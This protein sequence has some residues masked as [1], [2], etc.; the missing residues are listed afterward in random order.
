MLRR[1]ARTLLVLVAVLGLLPGVN[2]A[3]EHLGELIEHGHLAHSV[4][5]EHDPFGEEHGCT[6]VQ[7]QCPC[8]EGQ[9]VAYSI[10]GVGAADHAEWL[11]W[12][13]DADRARLRATS[14]RGPIGNDLAPANRSTA[15]PTPPANA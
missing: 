3:L 9:S 12:M 15:P 6:P 7:H 14:A 11:T 1:L 8:H 13:M 10:Y 2:E 5:G 4:P